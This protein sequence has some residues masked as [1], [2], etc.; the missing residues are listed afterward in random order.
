MG[1]FGSRPSLPPFEF[2]QRQSDIPVRQIDLSK[3]YDVYESHIG[4]DR[5][6]ENVRFVGIRTFEPIGGFGA[7]VVGGYLEIEAANGA[8]F[9]IPNHCVQFICEHGVQPTYRTLRVWD[10]R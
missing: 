8:Q 4:E 10:R 5:I 9:M 1:L 3:R 6:Y 2:P 7:G